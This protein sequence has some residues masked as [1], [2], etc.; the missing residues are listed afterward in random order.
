MAVLTVWVS[1]SMVA[2]L[3]LLSVMVVGRNCGSNIGDYRPC[4][5]LRV[6]SIFQ[7]SRENFET[8]P[9]P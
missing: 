3:L 6:E 1:V 8:G 7:F 9:R 2:M 5:Y 4:L